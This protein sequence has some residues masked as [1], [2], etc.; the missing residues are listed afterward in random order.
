[1]NSVFGEALSLR[2]SR[3]W[4][5]DAERQRYV[6]AVHAEPL[7]EVAGYWVY[8]NAPTDI[9]FSDQDNPP[10]NQIDLAEGW[11]AVSIPEGLVSYQV[12]NVFDHDDILVV[13]GWDAANQTYYQVTNTLSPDRGYWVYARR[14]LLLPLNLADFRTR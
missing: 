10:P 3:A 4:A 7:S 12:G 6:D 2:G 1:V 9:T 13:W 11:N 5:F 14:P 8:L